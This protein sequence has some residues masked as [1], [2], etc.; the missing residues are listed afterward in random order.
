M[1]QVK[2]VHMNTKSREQ[3]EAPVSKADNNRRFRDL[4]DRSGS[5][6]AEVLTRFNEGQVRPVSMSA[7]KS[8]LSDAG[9]V[10]FRPMGAS[11]LAHA[12]RVLA[13]APEKVS[14]KS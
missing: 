5:T 12:E 13:K 6:Q 9:S 2:L 1:N 11:L 4:V 10:R 14:N 8:W 7:I 3:A